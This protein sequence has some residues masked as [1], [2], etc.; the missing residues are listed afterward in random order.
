MLDPKANDPI[1]AWLPA[2]NQPSPQCLGASSSSWTATCPTSRTIKHVHATTLLL[3]VE[4]CHYPG[5][6]TVLATVTE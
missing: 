3:A 5:L 1:D 2:E 4:F 6:D